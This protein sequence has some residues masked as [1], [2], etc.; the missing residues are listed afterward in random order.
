VVVE[1]PRQHFLREA[2]EFP[3]VQRSLAADG[4]QPA[5]IVIEMREVRL[6]ACSASTT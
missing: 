4:E 6:R 2:A 1:R 5:A 3:K